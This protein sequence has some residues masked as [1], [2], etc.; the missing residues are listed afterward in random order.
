MKITT[1]VYRILGFVIISSIYYFVL[2]NRID[3][4]NQL[5]DLYDF[6]QEP[7]ILRSLQI[8]KL[9]TFS[10]IIAYFASIFTLNGFMFIITVNN[11]ITKKF[12]IK[13]TL[14]E[15]ISTIFLVI[16]SILL[17]GITSIQILLYAILTVYLLLLFAW[18]FTIHIKISDTKQMS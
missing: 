13:T 2:R 12:V 15:L 4:I 17:A 1:V 14:I 3:H 18:Q 5:Q 8:Q 16:L 10:W 11:N 6:G 9:I 7:G